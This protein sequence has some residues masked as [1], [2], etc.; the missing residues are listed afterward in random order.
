MAAQ[1]R[2]RRR[3]ADRRLRRSRRRQ[4][5]TIANLRSQY[6]QAR[7]RYAEL[8]TELGPPHPALKQMEQQVGDLRRTIAEEIDRFE[9]SA[10]NDLTRARDYEASLN[11]A[12]DAQ[13]RQSVRLS[14]ASVRLRELE[15]EVDASREVYQAFLKRSRGTEEQESLNTS[16]ARIVGEAT[17]PLRRSFLPA[18]SLIAMLGCLLGALA[19]AVFIVT[20]DRL[21]L[22]ET[23]KPEPAGDAA[24]AADAGT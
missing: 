13:K 17:V 9:Q 15:R 19:A 21:P 14:Q 11:R 2:D 1:G 12:L 23:D 6:A 20:L 22:P 4:S 16:A 8:T 18:M 24:E 3:R 5:P 7:K 10:R